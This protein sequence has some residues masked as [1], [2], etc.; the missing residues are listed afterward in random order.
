MR[1]S[2]GDKMFVGCRHFSD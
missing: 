2:V 1:V